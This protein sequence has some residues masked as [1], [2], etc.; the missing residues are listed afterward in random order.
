MVR[1][2]DARFASSRPSPRLVRAKDDSPA[3]AGGGQKLPELPPPRAAFTRIS[4]LDL[5][6]RLTLR[7]RC[8]DSFFY[9]RPDATADGQEQVQSIVLLLWL[10]RVLDAFERPSSLAARVGKRRPERRLVKLLSSTCY[11][12]SSCGGLLHAILPCMLG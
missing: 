5:T 2:A 6:L 4:A 12:D 7:S 10:W 1:S 9:H 3:T 8:V 11:T